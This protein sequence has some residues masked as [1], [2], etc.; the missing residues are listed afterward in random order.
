MKLSNERVY[1]IKFAI[2]P[3]K[4]MTKIFVE[5]TDNRNGYYKDVE[6]CVDISVQFARAVIEANNAEVLKD[7][8]PKVISYSHNWD[9]ITGYSADQMA[10]VVQERD[11]LKEMLEKLYTNYIRLLH[12]GKERIEDCGGTCD[13]VEQMVQSDPCLREVRKVFSTLKATS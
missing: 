11:A 7:M 10:A 3:Q 8:A 5:E 6:R 9:G 4:Y 1:E 2:E 12:V 13:S